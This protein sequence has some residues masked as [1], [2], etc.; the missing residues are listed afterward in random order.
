MK[1]VGKIK[2]L[3]MDIEGR[4]MATFTLENLH[5]MQMI[6][7]LDREKTYS[8]D[9][10]EAKSKRSLQQNKYL[11]ALLSDIDKRVNGERS[12]DEWSIYINALERTGA[13]YEYIVCIKEAEEL[14]KENFRAIKFIKNVDVNGKEGCM[15]KCFYGSSKM[16][17]K[18]FSLLIET[19]LDMAQAVGIETTYYENLLGV[20]R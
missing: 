13:K 3:M 17:T 6:K 9:I 4:G 2:E 18:E 14:L 12:N 16:N 7:E 5:H 11:W 19:V 10:K 15:F 8:I 1:I 20:E